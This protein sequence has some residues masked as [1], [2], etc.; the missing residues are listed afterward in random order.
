MDRF[1]ETNKWNKNN[2]L[3]TIWTRWDLIPR[4]HTQ[5]VPVDVVEDGGCMWSASGNEETR[6]ELINDESNEQ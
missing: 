5:H 4:N 6:I 1:D 2:V 3:E